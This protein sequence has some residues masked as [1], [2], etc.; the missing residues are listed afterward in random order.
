MVRPVSAVIIGLNEEK[1]IERCLASLCWADEIVFVDGGSQDRTLELCQKQEAPWASRIHIEK[2][3]WDGFRNQR[4][5]SLDVAKNEWVLVV[6]A[7]ECCTPELEKKIKDLMSLP[8]GPARKAYKVRRVEYFLGKEIKG[9]IWNPSY[10]DRFF[11]RKGVRYINNVHEYP[12]FASDPDLIHE[13]LEHFPD[14]TVERL[15]DKMNRYTTVEALDRVERGVRT[16]LFRMFFAFPAMFLKTYFYYG[17]YRDGVHGF[18][19]S[20]LEG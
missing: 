9:G 4:N 13:P 10:Q 7:D 2:R 20:L 11:N 14:V 5:Y 16:N 12:K 8:D 1:N 15:L 18:V 6:D 19:I 3:A 17:G